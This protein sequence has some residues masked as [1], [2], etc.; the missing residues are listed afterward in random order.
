M[1][2]LVV[3]FFLQILVT[4][5]ANASTVL[6]DGLAGADPAQPFDVFGSAGTGI[7]AGQFVGPRFSIAEPG[8]LTEIGAFLNNCDSIV[9]G[10]P[11]CPDTHPFVVQLRPS[12]DGLLPHPSLVLATLLLSHDDDP[13]LIS[14]ESVR[15]KLRLEPGTYFALFAPQEPDEAG[16]LLGNANTGG[17][18]A[19]AITM[20]AIYPDRRELLEKP[21]AARIVVSPVPIPATLPLLALGVGLLGVTRRLR[22]G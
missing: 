21:A 15:P 12:I 10:A 6:V 17:Y 14:Y 7:T 11:L 18:F 16:F 1:R 4:G 3:V 13:L 5:A 9:A 19:D 22:S 20:G 8:F 2:T